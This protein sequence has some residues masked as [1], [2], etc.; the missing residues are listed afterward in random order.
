[1][2][3]RKILIDAIASGDVKRLKRLR[4]YTY[5]G[6][7]ISAP[8]NGKYFII[9]SSRGVERKEIS[10]AEIE[11]LKEDHTVICLTTAE[12]EIT[13]GVSHSEEEVIQKM[14]DAGEWI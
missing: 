3:N 6:V 7:L 10:L 8:C 12:G 13:G 5:P 4:K 2:S 9:S 11:K 14:K 1:M